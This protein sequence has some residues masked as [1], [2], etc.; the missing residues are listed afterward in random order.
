MAWELNE[1]GLKHKV[2]DPFALLDDV[3][4]EGREDAGNLRSPELLSY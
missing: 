3:G 4:R 1:L 2:G